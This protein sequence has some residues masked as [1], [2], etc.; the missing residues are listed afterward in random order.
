MA[1]YKYALL[2]LLLLLL[3]S[4]LLAYFAF[5]KFTVSHT[6]ASKCCTDLKH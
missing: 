6:V 4:L 3:L 5:T 1:L 2:L